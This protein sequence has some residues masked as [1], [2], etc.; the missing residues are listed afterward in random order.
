M[1]GLL[2]IFLILTSGCGKSASDFDKSVEFKK[3]SLMRARGGDVS[4]C[5][6]FVIEEER[7]VCRD[8]YYFSRAKEEGDLSLC[9]NIRDEQFKEACFG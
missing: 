8:E 7:I 4:A 3:D 9:E 5:D 6:E 1:L 2:S